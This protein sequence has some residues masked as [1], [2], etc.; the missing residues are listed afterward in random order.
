MVLDR[1]MREE[2]ASAPTAGLGPAPERERR[3][4]GEA[5]EEGGSRELQRRELLG[6]KIKGVLVMACKVLERGE[7][8]GL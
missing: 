2:P 6:P 5:G 8:L 7:R 3:D 1:A 4:N